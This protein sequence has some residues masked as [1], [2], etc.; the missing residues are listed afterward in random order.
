MVGE[1]AWTKKGLFAELEALGEHKVREQLAA[2]LYGLPGKEGAKRPLVEVWLRWQEEARDGASQFEEASRA[3]DA[4][5][6]ANAR[7]TIALTVATV[8]AVT[9]IVSMIVSV[10]R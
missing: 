4:A 2:G 3:A 7:A 6:R 10:M 8:S 5:E 1:T 9:A